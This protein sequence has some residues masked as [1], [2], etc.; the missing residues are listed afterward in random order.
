M[1]STR[2]YSSNHSRTVSGIC[3]EPVDQGLIDGIAVGLGSLTKA[4]SQD[5]RKLENGYVRSYAL[6]VL[7]GIVLIFTY[8]VL[9]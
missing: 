8:L 2:P 5:L 4:I 3:A 9:R 1:S 6:S 7:V